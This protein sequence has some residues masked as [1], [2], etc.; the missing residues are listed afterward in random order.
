VID[1][2]YGILDGPEANALFAEKK[3][4]VSASG[5]KSVRL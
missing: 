5:R 4:Q 1:K 2:L 3:K